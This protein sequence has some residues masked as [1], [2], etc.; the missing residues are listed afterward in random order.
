MFGLNTRVAPFDDPDAR[1]AVAYALDRR[2]VVAAAG[3]REIAR[4]TCQVLPPG[5]PGSRPYCP[6]T[7]P[8]T[9]GAAGRPDLAEARRLLPRSKAG[10]VHVTVQAPDMLPPVADEMAKA[11]RRLGFTASVR[12]LRPDRH[13]DSAFD[14]S[15]RVQV[16]VLPFIAQL[17][18][19]AEALLPFACDSLTLND[20]F[21]TNYSQFCDP[22]VDRLTAEAARLQAVSPGRADEQWTQAEQRIV[23]AA[24][25]IAAYNR[26]WPDLVS[27][28]L[29]NFQ[30]NPVSGMLLDQ[31]W[32]R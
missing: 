21:N 19:A 27:E 15:K 24:P 13:F 31:A 28:R 4:E 32:V 12:V 25:A 2:A 7:V 6:F 20:P 18:S 5:F 3:G 17:P 10:G 23:D 30:Y 1:R 29:G 16:S 26:I 22:E 11:L 14:T 9:G 8:G